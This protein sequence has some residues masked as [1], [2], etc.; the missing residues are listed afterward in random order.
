MI[1]NHVVEDSHLRWHFNSSQDRF[2]F[3]TKFP[4][5]LTKTC[6]VVRQEALR[7]L[8]DNTHV[9][10]CGT[11]QPYTNLILILQRSSLQHSS[12]YR[13]VHQPFI[14]VLGPSPFAS[15]LCTDWI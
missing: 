1:Y 3:A 6:K 4:D 9:H 13:G 2:A 5:A 10:I 12:T 15:G 14:I 7:L 8:H 11:Q